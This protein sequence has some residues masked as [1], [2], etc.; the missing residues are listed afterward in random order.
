MNIERIRSWVAENTIMLAV[1]LAATI[2]IVAIVGFLVTS[3]LSEKSD[4]DALQVQ[5]QKFREIVARPT[6]RLAEL[7]EEFDLVRQGFPSAELTEIDVFRAFQE[8]AFDFGL[9]PSRV[10][11]QQTGNVPKK[12]IGNS[13]YRVISFALQV[14]GKSD[15]VSSLLQALDQGETR[16]K[17]LVLG[18]VSVSGAD[19][20]SAS[21]K[22]D[23][24]TLPADA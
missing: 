9:E 14:D 23:I 24:F 1:A 16:F 10:E 18:D 2:T 4:Q 8:L 15:L 17:T 22:F 3:Y 19:D 13:E 21:I 7:Q 5:L 12:K 20:L 6:S 11:L